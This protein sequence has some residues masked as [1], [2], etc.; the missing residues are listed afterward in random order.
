[1]FVRRLYSNVNV[2][3]SY[4]RLV[5]S[6][7]S[8]H[9]LFEKPLPPRVVIVESDITEA[10]LK[11][12]GPGGQKIN[13]TS[14]A[15]QLKHLP[16]GIVVKCQETRSRAQNRKLARRIL[17]DRLEE[18]EKGPQSRTALKAE[19]DRKKKASASKKSKRK[20]RELE[21]GK[22]GE[23]ELDTAAKEHGSTDDLIEGEGPAPAD[24][25]K[26]TGVN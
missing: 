22:T 25:T 17:G 15:V 11:G 21:T 10:F 12:S 18:M 23:Q 1:M 13:K 24:E 2:V 5:R 20:Y 26:A 8:R 19:R 9:A 16:T 7:S 6:F 4:W 3:P 14:S